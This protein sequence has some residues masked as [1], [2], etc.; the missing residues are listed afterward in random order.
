MS[1]KLIL[2]I[3]LGSTRIKSVL[4]DARS[5]VL[6]SGSSTW[7]NKLEDGWWT[8]SLDAVRDGVRASFAALSAEFGGV[9]EHLDAIGVS[10]M[11]HGYLAF[12]RDRRLLVPFRTWRNTATSRAA[13]ELSYAFDFNIPERWSC[14]HLYEAVLRGEEH[15]GRVAHLTTL[16]GYLHFM[17]SGEDVLGI[18]DASGVFPVSDGAYD[19]RMLGIFNSLLHSHGFTA[20]A[21][22]LLPRIL[23]AGEPAGRLTR[24][25]AEYLD[26]TGTLKPG[27]LLCPPEGDM[28]TGMAATASVRPGYANL[29]AGTSANLTLVLDRPL[30]RRH[31]ETDVIAT[32]D[33][34]AA[35]LIHTNNCTSEINAWVSLFGEVAALFGAEPPR[36]V[37]FDRLFEAAAA[38][39]GNVGGLIGYDHTSGE[40]LA[41]TS[42]GAPL[43]VREEGGRL[44]LANFMQMQIYSAL[45]ALTLGLDALK[46]EGAKIR[47][48]T[49]HGGFYKTARV[50]QLATSAMLGVPVTVMEN[51]DAG[52]AWGIALLAGFMLAGG[53]SLADHLDGIFADTRRLTLTA[54]AS[55]TE[56]CAAYLAGYRKYLP[57]CRLAG[58]ADPTAASAGGKESSNA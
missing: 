15:V 53:G 45:S 32:P 13:S 42:H 48:V 31:N 55:E 6:A 26:P 19:S 44:T 36:H 11:M 18:G 27:P 50:G 23:M 24:E 4:T 10:A 22:S 57:L 7:E 51:S 34:G 2:G 52:G 54:D 3:E 14:A 39:D 40:P 43:C 5:M 47:S 1:Q 41:G 56:K 21:E 16:A 29:S 17:L 25:G 28:Q 8:Y 46:D 37:L 20:D 30:S 49:A 38:S 33:G 12:D 58:K 9:P 35:A